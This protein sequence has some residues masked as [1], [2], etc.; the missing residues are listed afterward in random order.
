M[1]AVRRGRIRFYV[2]PRLPR[3]DMACLLL[4]HAALRWRH[5]TALSRNKEKNNHNWKAVQN[6]QH[7]MHITPRGCLLLDSDYSCGWMSLS[8]STRTLSSNS[9]SSRQARTMATT[10]LVAVL[11][12]LHVSPHFT[13]L[14]H[15]PLTRWRW[16][17]DAGSHRS[18][19]LL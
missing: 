5:S 6:D 19:F 10:P 7:I 1:L 11:V 2:Q 4:P 8:N 12:A 15:V 18:V 9:S 13:R 3:K 17:Q 16:L 14:F